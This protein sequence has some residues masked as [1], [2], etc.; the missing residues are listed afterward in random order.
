MSLPVFCRFLGVIGALV[1][2]PGVP[3]EIPADES[4]P[5]VALIIGNAKYNSH[6]YTLK[7]P[8]H[9]A[10]EIR[11]K[12]ADL[13]FSI[14]EGLYLENATKQQLEDAFKKFAEE[15][16]H[17]QNAIGLVYYSG[18]GLQDKDVYL[19]P[20]DAKTD[21]LSSKNPTLVS[22][23]TLMN[24]LQN[25]HNRLNIIIL[26]SCRTFP[27][28]GTKGVDR[29]PI[30]AIGNNI[31]ETLIAYATA[32]GKTADDGPGNN[33]PYA[34]AL[35]EHLAKPETT[36]EKMFKLVRTSV[37]ERTKDK[38]LQIPWESTSLSTNFCFFSCPKTANSERVEDLDREVA[39]LKAKNKSLNEEHEELIQKI[40]GSNPRFSQ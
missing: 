20:V 22:T 25:A 5:R 6:G 27:S 15:L 14:P 17:T 30:L 11:K 35:L 31:P 37:G 39:I 4:Y 3:G 23:E 24:V 26:D 16:S 38:I 29:L 21:D 8:V 33:S 2:A 36:I 19:L 7:N 10:Q 18:H 40:S 32:P 12:L 1:S 9:D 13:H 28:N 34:E